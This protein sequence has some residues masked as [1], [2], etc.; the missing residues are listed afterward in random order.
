MQKM[1]RKS[2]GLVLQKMTRASLGWIVVIT[3]VC[4]SLGACVGRGPMVDTRIIV[5][6]IPPR[7]KMQTSDGEL[8]WGPCGPREAKWYFDIDM[9]RWNGDGVYLPTDI[10]VRNG[11]GVRI[12][13]S[14]YLGIQ[15]GIIDF[16]LVLDDKCKDQSK[17]FPSPGTYVSR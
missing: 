10:L 4:M 9:V 6:N 12:D 1:P 2:P 11:G 14:G 15:S 5:N 13:V 3:T 8:I 17:G 7:I 16:R